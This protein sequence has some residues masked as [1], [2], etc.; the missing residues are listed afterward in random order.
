VTQTLENK[1]LFS[2]LSATDIAVL[3]RYLFGSRWQTALSSRLGISRRIV[4]YWS[5]SKRPISRKYSRRIAQIVGER[6]NGRTAKER[7][8]YIGLI[9]SINSESARTLLLAMLAD[10]IEIRVRAVSM[11]ARNE[12]AADQPA[13]AGEK[14]AK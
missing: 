13:Y 11:L 12:R 8:N 9:K 2:R 1:D 14:S 7:A 10:E 5:G 6:H 3:G 4:S